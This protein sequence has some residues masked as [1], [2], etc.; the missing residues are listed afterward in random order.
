MGSLHQICLRWNNH[1]ANILQIFN[2]VLNSMDFVDCTL[3]CEGQSIK[4]H[5]II[6]SACSPYFHSLFLDNPCKHPIVILRDVKYLD[7]QCIVEYIYK[8][9]VSIDREQLSEFLRTAQ[10]LQI[11]GLSADDNDSSP[12]QPSIVQ[13]TVSD[14]F[15]SVT[16]DSRTISENSY[17]QNTGSSTE[18][19]STALPQPAKLRVSSPNV[20][21]KQK[22]KSR[23]TAAPLVPAKMPRLAPASWKEQRTVATPSPP[24]SKRNH[25]AETEIAASP[26]A[27]R[28]LD[29]ETPPPSTAKTRVVS[30][31][32]GYS[33]TEQQGVVES[34]DAI[35]ITVP[36]EEEDVR[37]KFEGG[38]ESPTGDEDVPYEGYSA[39][40]KLLGDMEASVGLSDASDG[41]D[42]S[43][44]STLDPGGGPSFS[45][46]GPSQ[47]GSNTDL[48]PF[49]KGLKWCNKTDQE[50]LKRGLSAIMIDGL[51]MAAV[52]R[53]CG[54]P[55]QTLSRYV[56]RVKEAMALQGVTLESENLWHSDFFNE[57]Q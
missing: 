5:K 10:A 28:V 34:E 20:S 37:V 23:S 47:G 52:A 27:S 49:L 53:S 1:Q 17:H 51:P 13:S 44:D 14:S 40:T 2:K 55:R 21:T 22:D 6:L 32:S 45:G 54:I 4:A 48:I 7:L 15:R 57:D 16:E 43:M 3:S 25:V 18:S 12:P 9:E 26:V 38:Q 31:T 39:D 29:K 24:V 19:F 41:G 30:E 33:A 11:K 35:S 56:R 46:A 36:D 8:G 42:V 50:K